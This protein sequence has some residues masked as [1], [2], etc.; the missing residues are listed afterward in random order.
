VPR[1]SLIAALTVAL[2]ISCA[3]AV[4]LGT[5]LFAFDGFGTLGMVHSSE[6]QADFTSTDFK[7]N[8]AGFSHDWSAD[9]DS[10]LGA[11]ITANATSQLSAT[12]QIIVEQSYN[13]S[14]RPSIDWANLK[15]QITPDLSVRLGRIVLPNF[16][17]S[18]YRKVG[19][20]YPWV[21]PPIEV[22]GTEPLI[23]NDGIDLSYRLHLGEV[24]STLTGSYGPKY[25][26]H[27]PGGLTAP[28]RNLMGIFDRTEYGSALFNV[29]YVQARISLDPP[30]PLFDA[31][32]EFGPQGVAIAD[33]YEFVD[34]LGQIL[35][36]GASYDP[37][38]WLAM[39]EWI[40]IDTR[41]FIGGSTG[42]YVSGGYRIAQFTPYLTYSAVTLATT[43]D[44]GLTVAALPPF[45]AGPATALNAGL[46]AVL[47]SRPVQRTISAGA[48]WNFAKN[49][50][51][52]LQCDHIR[53]G[54]GSPGTLINTQP[55]FRPGGTVNVFSTTVDFLF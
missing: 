36:F 1:P 11:Q 34:K 2:S 3:H 42:W 49:F 6:D 13:N 27:F 9:V 43:S 37:G 29:S 18:D 25:N 44:P 14:Y 21:R 55:G 39:A 40:R 52:K 4:D 8:G 46:N 16:L 45:L 23:Y 12:A 51:L 33:K 20:A 54:P 47:V 41:S 48:R 15:Y 50:D 31:F 30:I 32:R 35:A 22:Y 10:R 19:Y 53:L 17:V 38:N 26:I 7:P 28:A 24:T 5:S